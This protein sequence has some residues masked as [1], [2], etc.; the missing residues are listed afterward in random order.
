M[1]LREPDAKSGE[2]SVEFKETKGDIVT[3]DVSFEELDGD[4]QDDSEESEK[5]FDEIEDYCSESFSE[6][7]KSMERHRVNVSSGA[8]AR[9]GEKSWGP[10]RYSRLTLRRLVCKAWL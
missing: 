9:E 5:Y 10:A 7:G 2:A 8:W 6:R 4:V 3:R 1:F